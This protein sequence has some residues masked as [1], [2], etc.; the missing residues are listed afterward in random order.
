MTR[1][2]PLPRSCTLTSYGASTAWDCAIV[3][4]AKDEE[5]RV[6]PCLMA[7]AT[8]CRNVADHVSGIIL[9]INNTTDRTAVAA[10]EYALSQPD[11]P[12]V[13]IDCHFDPADAGVGSAR[14]LGLDLACRMVG[15]SG[16]LLTTDADTLVRPDWIAQNLAELL[17]ADMICGTVSGQPDEAQNLPPAIAAHGSAEWDYVN[18]CVALAAALDPLAHDTAPAHHNAAGASMAV[19]AR[20]YQAVGGL[21][22]IQIGEDRAFAERIEA[23][24]YRLRY[25]DRVIVETSCRMIGRT[26]G[27]MA[28]ALRARAFETDPFGDEWLEPAAA[29]ALRYRMRGGLRAVWPDLVGLHNV[30]SGCLSPSTA[31]RLLADPIPHHCG[32][33]I[34]KAENELPRVRLRLSDCRQELPQLQA[35][36]AG[37]DGRPAT[38]ATLCPVAA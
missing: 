31:D 16:T 15:Q 5:D 4:P 26:D 29:F 27:G 37:L 3:I 7:A 18:G 32:A 10:G 17:R 24:D 33:F 21:P 1:H 30:L 8:A 23:H 22:V 36:L 14:R 13:V 38:G 12:V 6:V 19:S 25:S 20:V 34:A 35:F 2:L 9:V 11:I 28:G